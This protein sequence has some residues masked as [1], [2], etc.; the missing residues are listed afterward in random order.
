MK[1]LATELTIILKIMEL[2]FTWGSS[3]RTSEYIRYI[4]G[5]IRYI[6]SRQSLTS[7]ELIRLRLATGIYTS[8][9]KILKFCKY[10]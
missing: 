8:E 6:H 10:E 4:L 7:Y 3:V 5:D 1:D 9:Y 2:Q